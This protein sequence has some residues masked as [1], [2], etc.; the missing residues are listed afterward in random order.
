MENYV[1]A[2]IGTNKLIEDSFGPRVGDILERN[3]LKNNNIKVFGTTKSPIHFKNATIFLDYIKKQQGMLIVIDSALGKIEN[4][5]CTYIST[6]GMEI[7][8]AFGRSL[9]FPA[10]LSIKTI[11][12]TQKN[13][14]IQKDMFKKKE[15]EN[16]KILIN[17]LAQNLANNIM[18]VIFQK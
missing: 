10:N 12:G 11:V 3:F 6:G 5:G 14:I 8:K 7:G 2:C 18:E 16:N 17:N 1:F 9:Y 4:I 13:C 15:Q